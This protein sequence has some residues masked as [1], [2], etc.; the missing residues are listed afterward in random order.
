MDLRNRD[1][2]YLSPI[3]LV[4]ECKKSQELMARHKKDWLGMDTR[5]YG[6]QWG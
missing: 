5:T 4:L 2:L 1:L 6:G 3:H